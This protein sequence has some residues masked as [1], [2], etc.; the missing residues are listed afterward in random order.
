MKFV[1]DAHLPSRLKNWLIEQGY[2]C[3][4][5]LDLPQEN[6]TDD[7]NIIKYADS[8]DR[9]IITKDSD[10]H[11]SNL[12]HGVPRRILMITTGNISNR[13]L[14]NLFDSNFAKMKSF[15]DKGNEIVEINN[16]SIFVHK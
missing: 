15:F 4:H 1:V 6:E 7:T 3:T 16:T 13:N 2:D 12:L 11:K 14:I 10:F 9:I 5:T 8:E